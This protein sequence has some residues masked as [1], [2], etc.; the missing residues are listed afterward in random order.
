MA[1]VHTIGIKSHNIKLIVHSKYQ[2]W[3]EYQIYKYKYK[4]EYL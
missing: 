3:G 4:S 2:G 1:L